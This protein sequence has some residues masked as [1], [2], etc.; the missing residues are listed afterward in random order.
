MN[1]LKF[2]DIPFSYSLVL[3]LKFIILTP[4]ISMFSES[5]E[6]NLPFLFVAGFLS[7]AL[8]IIDPL[9]NLFKLIARKRANIW[10]S[11]K[12][13]HEL[14]P[15]KVIPDG[16]SEK[17]N[18]V[19]DRF[20]RPAARSKIISLEIDRIV[21]KSYFLIL[22]MI[23]V[24]F[25]VSPNFIDLINTEMAN[26]TLQIS[27]LGY[28]LSAPITFF[29]TIIGMVIG[30]VIRIDLQNLHPKILSQAILMFAIDAGD[31]TK[32]E[33]LEKLI[34]EENWDLAEIHSKEY[35]EKH[36]L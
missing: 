19:M 21:S 2:V 14:G 22:V 11:Q 4:G 12:I 26:S 27:N 7:T 36:T 13:I 17:K 33:K 24:I 15:E 25:S 31:G 1:F 5:F 30:L 3:Y 9:G 16:E 34:A 35:L 10:F 32:V 28:E 18:Q 29:L 6:S 23:L 20:Y 8:A